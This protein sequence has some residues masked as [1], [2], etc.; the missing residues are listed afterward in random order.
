M[1]PKTYGDKWETIRTLGEG[2]QSHVYLVRDKTV[3]YQG[4]Y[5]LKRL[6][7]K[8]RLGRFEDEIK[9]LMEIDHPNV[10]KIVDYEIN[11][12]EKYQYIVTE[13]CKGGALSEVKNPFWHGSL[14][15]QFRIV[16]EICQILT[17]QINNK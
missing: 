2:G 15:E 11:P 3:E 10:L 14:E 7:N 8:K 16:E 9:A 1:A 17:V 5:V 6:K 12:E 4:E 13:Y